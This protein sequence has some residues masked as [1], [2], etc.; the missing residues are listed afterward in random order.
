MHFQKLPA[1]VLNVRRPN[2]PILGG[3][4]PLLGTCPQIKKSPMDTM[5]LK[6][7]PQ[8]SQLFEI[9]IWKLQFNI[10]QKF[11]IDYF[12]KNIF[13]L[14]NEFYLFPWPQ[15]FLHFFIPSQQNLELDIGRAMV[16]GSSLIK[17]HHVHQWSPVHEKYIVIVMASKFP[18]KSILWGYL[19]KVMD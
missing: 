14:L 7:C 1:V 19:V 18:V 4:S 8:L 10:L 3:Q 15:F 13:N 5:F 12:R 17:D 16:R 6:F 9:Y 2:V 11:I